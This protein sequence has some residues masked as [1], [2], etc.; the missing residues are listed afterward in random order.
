MSAPDRS[1]ALSTYRAKRDFQ[2]TPEPRGRRRRAKARSRKTGLY[3]IQKHAARRLHYDLRLEL[4]GVLKSWAITRGPSLDP[5]NKRLAVRTEDHPLEYA[6]FE[7]RIPE[8]SYGAGT[9]LLWDRGSWEPLGDP[10]Q[11]LKRGKLTFRLHGE[12]LKGPWALVRFKGKEGG[13]RENWL[14]IKEKGEA[15]DRRREI[16]S[17]ETVSVA[18]GRDLAAIAAAPEAIWGGKDGAIDLDSKEKR[19]P[20][21][22]R[23]T[24]GGKLPAF[25]EPALATLVEAVPRGAKWL[26][27]MKF[28]GYR[29]ITAAAGD[30]VRIHTRS[31]LDWTARYPTIAER[32][33]AMN[34]P[35]V[36]LDGEI[37][38]IDNKGH[39]DFGALQR[40]LK[41]GST[42]LSY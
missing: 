11:G 42:G 24:T 36:L 13:K 15:A 2:D 38:A 32:L 35:R 12:R 20:P 9:V 8:G 21:R 29:A 19:A 41:R 1:D 18:S 25:V 4:D 27:E 5:S 39:S 17:Q 7:G 34:L 33:G 16:T 30:K 37:V 10:H 40:A 22:R 3:T 28:D 26:F 14:L 6:E 23:A 31:G